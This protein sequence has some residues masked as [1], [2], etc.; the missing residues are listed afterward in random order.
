MRYLLL[1]SAL[2]LWGVVTVASAEA[3][4][5]P[6]GTVIWNDGAQR[7]TTVKRTVYLDRVMLEELK[8]S[9]PGRYALVRQVMAAAGDFCGASAARQ[10]TIA[11]VQTASCSGALLKTSFPPKR[12]IGF[13]VEDTWYV[14][15]VTV[16]DKPAKLIAA[17]DTVVPLNQAK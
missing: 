15:L 3:P 10:W 1:S 16:R 7:P 11:N 12:E 4:V 8:K 2:L 9:N 5:V 6:S 13:Q 14:A 17:P